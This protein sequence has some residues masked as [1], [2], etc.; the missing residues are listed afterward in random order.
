MSA[1]SAQTRRPFLNSPFEE[2]APA[3]SPDGRWL[4]Y[5]SDESGS[6]EVYV[7]AYP[8]PAGRWQVSLN[9]GIEPRWAA[10][11]REIFYRSGDS[12]IAVSVTTQ[13]TFAPGAR[14][15]LFA[16]WYLRESNHA[17]YDVHPDGQRF[18]MV[19]GGTERAAL[20]LVLG[21]ASDLRSRTA[22]GAR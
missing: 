22:G 5:V 14:Q 12:L 8:D 15:A 7:R 13:P 3:I 9:G 18:V 17:Q 1:D 19:R 6:D 4:A 11:G 21:F 2:R 10:S 20:V 16:R